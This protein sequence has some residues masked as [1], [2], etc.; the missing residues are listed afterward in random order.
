MS[1]RALAYWRTGG[2]A[3][4]SV[5][6][7]WRPLAFELASAAVTPSAVDALCRDGFVVLDDVAP[8]ETL[9]AARASAEHLRADGKMRHVGQEGR[10]DAVAVLDASSLP[11]S[12]SRYGGLAGAAALTLA[13]AEALRVRSA[14]TALLT[15][16]EKTKRTPRAARTL[17][18]LR[19]VQP[20]SRLMLAHYPGD[21]NAGARYVPHLDNDPEDPGADDGAPGL[22]ARDRAV[23]A[24]L[25][26]NPDWEEAHG[27]C[28][29]VRLEDE[30]G[31][32]DI[33]PAWGRVVLF[34][35]RRITH[36]VRPARHGRWAL[37]AWIND[38]PDG[39]P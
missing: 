17:D 23:T 14:E 26:L 32:V 21:E 33:A 13:F 35:S 18:R 2:L 4:S 39:A 12:R 34:D 25:Y 8:P 7:C 24:I 6:A 22:R 27:G 3:G 19:G 11:S 30:K 28:L 10:D 16:K 38:G 9:L 37:T 36:E 5:L 31:E 29:R 20:P 15:N 1:E